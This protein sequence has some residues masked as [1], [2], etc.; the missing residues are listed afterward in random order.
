[1]KKS[2]FLF[3]VSFFCC[4]VVVP[5]QTQAKSDNSELLSDWIGLQLKF[6]RSTKGITQGHVTKQFMTNSIVFYEC[7]ATGDKQYNS[8]AGQVQQLE[9]LPKPPSDNLHK[10]AAANSAYAFMLRK[11]FGA[12]AANVV[13]VDSLESAYLSKFAGDG[14]SSEQLQVAANYGKSVAGAI[15]IWT[16]TDGSATK[17]PPYEIPKGEGKWE[18]TPPVFM[19][20]AA[21][22]MINFRESVKGSNDNTLP[23]APVAFSTDPSSAFYKMVKEVHDV[24]SKLTPEQKAIALFWDDLPDGRYYGGVGHWCSILRQVLKANKISMMKG[25]EAFAKMTIAAGDA[26]LACWKGKYTYNVLRP[27]TYI[28]K[29]MGLPE[30]KPVIVTPN[31]PEYPAAHA[32]VSMASA[33]AL[34]DVLGKSVSFVDHTYDDIGFTARTF[35]SFDQA[36]K[37]A[38]QSRLYGGIHYTPSIDAGYVL[39]LK[40]AQNVLRGLKVRNK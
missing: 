31:H 34:T 8:L 16:G 6:I 26:Q 25:A 5:A 11:F 10:S 4:A 30:W 3:C 17:F 21:P 38:G 1:M 33:T 40:T 39:G 18:P 2:L 14:Y 13:R 37:E 12:D 15:L 28:N 24:S 22:Q 19:P 27:V 9:N 7:V 32:S 20:P 29:Y 35:G 36:A 23:P